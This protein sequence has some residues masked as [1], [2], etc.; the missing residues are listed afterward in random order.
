MVKCFVLCIQ[1]TAAKYPKHEK[2]F[3]IKGDLKDI[4]TKKKRP[5]HFCFS[6]TCMDSLYGG[7]LNNIE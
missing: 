1:H 2:R 4:T 3:W 6:R 5:G 7:T